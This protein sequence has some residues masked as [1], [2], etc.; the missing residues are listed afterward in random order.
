M[1][2]SGTLCFWDKLS[3]HASSASA[4]LQPQWPR[5]VL[6]IAR[7][8]L[9]SCTW[10]LL[11][12]SL[13]PC[14]A[15]QCP[16]P[17]QEPPDPGSR[18]ICFSKRNGSAS[19]TL[20]LTHSCSRPPDWARLSSRT[21]PKTQAS[22][23][24]MPFRAAESPQPACCHLLLEGTK[25]TLRLLG[26]RGCPAR[27]LRQRADAERW[28]AVGCSEGERHR[29]AHGVRPAEVPCEVTDIRL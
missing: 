5:P 18:K 19:L 2:C 10:L 9:F 8:C 12:L 21:W 28:V 20:I 7:L 27:S 23:R 13:V 26:A 4:L 1:E 11:T 16:S 25:L 3:P 15:P 24:K 6:Q 17:L 14:T 22:R 29:P